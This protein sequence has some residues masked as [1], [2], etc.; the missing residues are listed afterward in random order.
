MFDKIY[1][2]ID[3]VFIALICAYLVFFILLVFILILRGDKTKRAKA[4]AAR[5]LH[6]T[7]K[8]ELRDLKKIKRKMK[9]SFISR[10][11]LL[12]KDKLEQLKL[13]FAKK[14]KSKKKKNVEQIKNKKNKNK[15]KNIKKKNKKNKKKSKKVK[16]KKK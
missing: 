8:L 4:N 3:I 15:R 16:N 11:K 5:E 14:K 9:P 13:I 6:Y 7:Q 12:F 10:L 2:P 1:D